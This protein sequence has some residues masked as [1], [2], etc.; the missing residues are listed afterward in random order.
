MFPNKLETFLNEI[1]V[2][3]RNKNWF[4]KIGNGFPKIG[5]GFPKIGNR[6]PKIGNGFPKIG[7][8]LGISNWKHVR[9]LK[10]EY[11]VEEIN[12]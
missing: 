9:I 12:C 4:L 7:N 2:S 6:F 1:K 3:K 5:N 10:K 11:V 8:M